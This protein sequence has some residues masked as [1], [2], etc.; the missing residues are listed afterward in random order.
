MIDEALTDDSA[1]H[2]E[3]E[4]TLVRPAGAT[5]NLVT[6]DNFFVL[7]HCR[8]EWIQR[9]RPVTESILPNG[10]RTLAIA[11]VYEMSPEET[12]S[13]NTALDLVERFSALIGL[14]KWLRRY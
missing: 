8:Y 5:I 2:T 11:E 14:S 3:I 10:N 9:S 7:P 13:T 6:N 12:G 1:S 4:L